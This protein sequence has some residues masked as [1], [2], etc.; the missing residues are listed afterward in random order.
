MAYERPTID[1]IVSR[2]ESD[3]ES[4][5]TGNIS[6][7]RRGIL[8]VLARV[9]AGAVHILYGYLEYLSEQLFATT[10]ELTYLNRIGL[11]FGV[12][13]KAASFAEG[14]LTFDGDDS[15]V[16]PEGTR[17]IREDGIEYET[18]EEG[19]I[20]GGFVEV[21]G[22]AVEAGTSGNASPGQT[23]DLVE[24][25]V[26]VDSVNITTLFQ[27]GEDEESDDDYRARILLRIQTPPA[28][29]TAAD[30]VRWAK[31][32]SGVDNAWCFP[33]F[34][35][36][37]Q[38]TVVYKG[39]AAIA[40]VQEY[41]EARMPVT[42][43][44]TVQGTDD[45]DVDFQIGITPNTQAFRDAITANLTQ[46]FEEVAAPGENILISAVRNA[47][48]T[49]GVD[50]YVIYIITVDGGSRPVNSD[51]VFEDFEYGVLDDLTFLSL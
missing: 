36:P 20:S 17:V 47:I 44:L 38:V 22:I 2:I 12:T 43:D 5:L 14:T 37:G 23:V 19:T 49:S 34:P 15:T 3:M 16:I 35:G 7:L 39:T 11:M 31:E 26:G 29:G 33:A 6:L 1:T 50:N 21:D 10:A 46:L 32:V 51:I 13:R 8:R 28:G 18:T 42:T 4:R 25:I 30:F 27:G 48:S 9:F 45:L 41:L 24:P 40:T